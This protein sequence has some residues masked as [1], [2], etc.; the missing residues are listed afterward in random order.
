MTQILMT[1]PFTKGGQRPGQRLTL[2][3]GGGHHTLRPPLRRVLP[4]PSDYHDHPVH[5]LLNCRN[6]R[7]KHTVNSDVNVPELFSACKCT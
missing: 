7:N 4:A 6:S 1:P 3:E 2:G 5:H